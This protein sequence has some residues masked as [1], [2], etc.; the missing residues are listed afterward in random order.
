MTDKTNADQN[1][2]PQ[3]V[4]ADPSGRFDFTQDWTRQFRGN[5]AKHMRKYMLD[6]AA[7]QP[8][9]PLKYLEVGVFEGRSGCHVLDNYNNL[10]YTGIDLWQTQGLSPIYYPAA[11]D[12]AIG[13]IEARARK[14]LGW[15]QERDR[16]VTI[17]KGQATRCSSELLEAGKRF[18]WIYIDAAHFAL[19]VVAEAAICWQMLE[20]GG[21]MLFDDY[22]DRGARCT[23]LSGGEAFLSLV[24]HS[25]LFQNHQLAV[26]KTED[27][28]TQPLYRVRKLGA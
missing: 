16:A 1:Q 18:D 21:M 22:K 26:I 9:Q 4:V 7:A 25:R 11:D 10:E 12:D 8:N 20:V 3:A 15:F 23:T 14:N 17:L 27:C 24:K 28:Q 6:Y 5:D 2:E 13:E 19:N